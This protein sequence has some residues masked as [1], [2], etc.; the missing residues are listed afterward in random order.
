MSGV[1]INRKLQT[2]QNH[3]IVPSS[4]I[5][6][7]NVRADIVGLS[8]SI[9]PSDVNKRIKVSIRW[10]GEFNGDNHDSVFGVSRNGIDIA[11]QPNAGNRAS[12]IAIIS[13]G[14]WGNNK[15]S[16]PDSAIFSYVDSPLSI[17]PQL[18]SATIL[19]QLSGYLYNN[20]TSKDINSAIY[21]RITS[22]IILEEID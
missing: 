2:V 18:Y 9:T 6:T 4:Q 22:T 12:G 11:N 17:D 8:A 20:R 10:C 13:Q 19:M 15:Y 7:A 1:H 3:V 14:Y 16:T 5:L 21:E